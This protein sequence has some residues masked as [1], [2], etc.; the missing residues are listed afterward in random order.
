VACLRNGVI[1]GQVCCS[2][3]SQSYKFELVPT[4]PRD[5]LAELELSTE[6]NRLSLDYVLTEP[7]N[8]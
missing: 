1:E 6:L 3:T 2:I 7:G 4:R 5:R 8:Y